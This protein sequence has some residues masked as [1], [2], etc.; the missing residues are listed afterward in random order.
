M[1]QISAA[2][3]GQFCMGSF[4]RKTIDIPGS[5]EAGE[6]VDYGEG[7]AAGSGVFLV[8]RAEDCNRRA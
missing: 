1:A 4:S 6:T 8:I 5:D 7:M 3:R 2:A